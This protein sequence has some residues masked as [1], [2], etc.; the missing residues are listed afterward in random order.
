M[1]K[2]FVD[3]MLKHI[4]ERTVF[5][6]GD[7]GFG[8]LEPVREALQNRFINAGIAEQNMVSAA[9]GIAKTGLTTWAYSIAPFI[10]ARPFEQIRNDVCL[11]NLPVHLVGN[12]GGYGYGVMGATHHAL[13]DY[14]VLLTLPNMQVYVP[15]FGG[16]LD[17]IV[18]RI[19]SAANPTYLRLGKSELEVEGEYAPWRKLRSGNGPV[20][21]TLGALSGSTYEAVKD[22]DID[23]WVVT[24][25]PI[26]PE[27]IPDFRG[28]SVWVVEEH[29]AQG[30][31]G[32]MLAAHLLQKI[33]RLFEFRHFCAKGYPSH[34][35][36]SQNFHRKECGIDAAFIREQILLRG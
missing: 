3:A 21:V 34:T 7:L 23:F 1:R 33:Y 32:H 26:I 31:F 22:L 25:L 29:I 27:D 16:D 9:A 28:R 13:E 18:G 4:T 20:I 2:P 6:T 17:P 8:A 35:Y 36:G 24:E 10:Y 30:S 15:A 12:G 14:G 11:H 5:L 19:Q